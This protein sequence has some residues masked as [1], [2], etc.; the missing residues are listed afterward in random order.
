M[1][2]FQDIFGC[3]FGVILTFSFSTDSPNPHIGCILLTEYRN[4]L[5][6]IRR[7]K[8]VAVH[9][10]TA[11][12]RARAMLFLWSSVI[13]WL[14]LKSF[15]SGDI[16][17]PIAIILVMKLF[18]WSNGL[19]VTMFILYF[20]DPYE[21]ALCCVSVPWDFPHSTSAYRLVTPLRCK[22]MS[23]YRTIRRE[24]IHNGGPGFFLKLS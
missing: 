19:S 6:R 7:G 24:T 16:F 11:V 10:I 17:M 9:S 4:D 5:T 1:L 13:G 8:Y 12:H 2:K 3:G 15:M 22:N 14:I 23:K 18:Q 21:V 20:C